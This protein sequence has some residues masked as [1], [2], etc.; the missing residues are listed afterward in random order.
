M[1]YDLVKYFLYFKAFYSIASWLNRCYS[2]DVIQVH[3][4]FCVP[5]FSTILWQDL[6]RLWYFLGDGRSSDFLF[7]NYN[8]QSSGYFNT[9]ALDLELNLFYPLVTEGAVWKMRVAS[10]CGAFWTWSHPRV[11]ALLR[12][13]LSP[14]LT[15]PHLT[16]T[17]FVPSSYDRCP[18]GK[19]PIK[20]DPRSH[21]F[22]GC[23]V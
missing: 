19:D 5:R 6:W 16:W 20:N 15:M 1:H 7:D 8:V 10:P 13:F 9:L 14:P 11:P 23:H 4:Y 21:S 17:T 12:V 3:I 2:G 18:L 22:S